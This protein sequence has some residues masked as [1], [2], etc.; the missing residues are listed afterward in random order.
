MAVRLVAEMVD[1]MA[2]M[3][4]MKSVAWSAECLVGLRAGCLGTKLA[5]PGVGWS[6]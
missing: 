4:V 2:D 1:Q 5:I 3:L 6:D